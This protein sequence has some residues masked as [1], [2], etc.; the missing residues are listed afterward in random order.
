MFVGS[1]TGARPVGRATKT[2]PDPQPLEVHSPTFDES[3]TVGHFVGA[4]TNAPAKSSCCEHTCALST[5]HC[6]CASEYSSVAHV[7]KKLTGAASEA[8]A[9]SAS[10]ARTRAIRVRLRGRLPA[11]SLRCD[12]SFLQG[13]TGRCSPA[14][15]HMSSREVLPH[16]NSSLLSL[17]SSSSLGVHRLLRRNRTACRVAPAALPSSSPTFPRDR[18]SSFWLHMS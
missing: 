16:S 9:E 15:A 18:C 12:E 6:P 5:K 1:H 11:V 13:P 10:S 17:A 4:R 7:R 2:W 8:A 3:V 14:A